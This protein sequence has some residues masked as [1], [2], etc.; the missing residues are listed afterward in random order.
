MRNPADLE[1]TAPTTIRLPVELLADLDEIARQRG[2]KRAEVIRHILRN[3][4][5]QLLK[6]PA[7]KKKAKPA[8]RK[9]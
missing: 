6:R 1:Q 8:K 3:A 2:Y 5:F 4:T 9:R 7:K